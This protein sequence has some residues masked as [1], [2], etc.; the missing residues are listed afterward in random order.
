MF[1]LRSNV[2]RCCP[3]MILSIW[4]VIVIR[5]Q[6]SVKKIVLK[7]Q[8]STKYL[9]IFT[10]K[11]FLLTHAVHFVK[12]GVVLY[13]SVPCFQKYLT[14]SRSRKF[15]F[16]TFLLWPLKTKNSVKFLI[17]QFSQISAYQ[18]LKVAIF[19]TEKNTSPLKRQLTKY[20]I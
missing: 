5:F 7:C 11:M 6:R 15:N 10:A 8:E 16:L 13:M 12:P 2:T 17:L 14:F 1:I 9:S 18:A 19:N 20:L 3:W 4:F